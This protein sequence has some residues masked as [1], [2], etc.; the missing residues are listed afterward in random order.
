MPRGKKT[1]RPELIKSS[2][3]AARRRGRPARASASEDENEN[4]DDSFENLHRDKPS[5]STQG[6]GYVSDDPVDI[7]STSTGV[8]S[9]IQADDAQALEWFQRYGSFLDTMLTR[10]EEYASRLSELGDQM[11]SK[12][13]THVWKKGLKRQNDVAVKV[14]KKSKAA[15]AAIETGQTERASQYMQE[16]TNILTDRIKG[17][18]IVDI[19]EAGWETVNVYKSHLVA[20]DLDDDKNIRKA[21]KEAKERIATST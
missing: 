7:P 15:S 10:Q 16:G 4:L 5:Q 19:S 6:Q 3:L 11:D 18:K 9:S 1:D 17:L 14:L 12:E 8:T 13:Q 2:A 20:E 21:D